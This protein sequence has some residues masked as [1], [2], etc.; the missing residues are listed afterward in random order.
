MNTFKFLDEYIQI[1]GAPSNIRS[2]QTTFLIGNKV[3]K[4]CKENNFNIITTPVNDRRP[5]D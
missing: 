3:K 4:F 1:H 2:D 5:L